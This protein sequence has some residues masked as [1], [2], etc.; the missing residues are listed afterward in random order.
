MPGKTRQRA[1]RAAA[2][3]A[4]TVTFDELR[5]AV[6]ATFYPAIP[7]WDTTGQDRID[8]ATRRLLAAAGLDA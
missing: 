5:E 6:R 1:A 4:Y 8:R 3:E 2:S 7:A